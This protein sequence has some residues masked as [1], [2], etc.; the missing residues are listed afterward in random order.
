MTSIL[1]LTAF[2]EAA[3]PVD[4]GRLA[5]T[6]LDQLSLLQFAHMRLTAYS[7]LLRAVLTA[8][9]QDDQV[10]LHPALFTLNSAVCIHYI[11]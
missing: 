10:S 1:L 11:F 8:A 9:A 2:W 3:A 6:V 4:R 7:T 5:V